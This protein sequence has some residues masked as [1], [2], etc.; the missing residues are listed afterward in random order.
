MFQ[1]NKNISRGVTVHPLQL[2]MP[3]HS[4]EKKESNHEEMEV[5]YPEQDGSSS[6]EEDT[7]STSVSEDGDT[8]GRK[9]GLKSPPF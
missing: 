3:V 6:D 1:L 7:V 5:D 9:T 8:S 4:R 2:V